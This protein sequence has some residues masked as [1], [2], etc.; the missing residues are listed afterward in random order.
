MAR[1]SH[2][3]R[4]GRVVP[5][6]TRFDLSY[7]KKF[8]ADFG[9]LY[10]VMCDEVVP[11]DHFKIKA[12]SIVR[13]QPMFAP[14]LHEIS[15]TVHY[16]FVPYRI[17]WENWTDFISGGPDGTFK[18]AIPRFAGGIG[19]LTP[20]MCGLGTLWDYFGFPLEQTQDAAG[21]FNLATA[22]NASIPICFPLRAYNLIWEEYYRDENFMAKLGYPDWKTVITPPPPLSRLDGF[23]S[24][25]YKPYARS[26]VKDYFTSALP[27][28]QRGLSPA[29]PISGL[30]DV[31]IY[32]A[33]NN[34]LTSVPTAGL[35]VLI[36]STTQP[37]VGT[38]P[39]S[40][41]TGPNNIAVQSGYSAATGSFYRVRPDRITNTGSDQPAGKLKA[42]MTQAVS[43]NVKDLRNV[44]QLQKWLERNARGGVRYTEFLRAHFDVAP[45]DDRLQRPEY[46]GGIKNHLVVSEV[47][48]TSNS[49]GNSTGSSNTTPQGNMSGHG[50]MASAGNVGSYYAKEYGLIMGI[51]SIMA[52]PTYE[53]GIDRQWLRDINTDFY[54]P[55]F[56]NLS[57]QAIYNMEI[58]AKGGVANDPVNNTGER[59]G[60]GFQPQYDEMRIKRNMA[61]GIMR[62][63][64]GGAS[65]ANLSFWHLGRAWSTLPALNDNFVRA[66]GNSDNVPITNVNNGFMPSRAFAVTSVHPFIVAHAN[67]IQATRPLPYIGEP[68][69]VDHH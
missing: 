61:C 45:R 21:H 27:F 22:T 64:S 14:L 26:W 17:L 10:P 18:P 37:L 6:R 63:N 7:E 46:I 66:H 41:G 35:T 11:G 42:D 15:H 5:P 69:L 32:D 51:M 1:G 8:T 39:Y 52:T 2:H 62:V 28:Q 67:I 9:R 44:V 49:Q 57:E 3:N 68:G 55:E 43:F 13:M 4:V 25:S 40:S 65:R 47:L 20:A 53:D 29:F 38:V 23:V 33:N 54:F 16:F 34:N 56:V 58:F 60:W 30:L 19:T 12:Q 59:D 50:V 36:P 48:Q 24:A 31:N